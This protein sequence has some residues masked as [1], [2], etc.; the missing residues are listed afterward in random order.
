MIEF[1][2][3]ILTW[4]VVAAVALFWFR[5]E[6]KGLLTMLQKTR[7]AS[8]PNGAVIDFAAGDQVQRQPAETIQNR[9]FR[10]ETVEIDG[11]IFR[12]CRFENVILKYSG[13][14]PFSLQ[15]SQF[16]GSLQF[17]FA[18]PAAN[19]VEA[20]TAMYTGFGDLGRQ[21]VEMFFDSI[22]NP[23]QQRPQQK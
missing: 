16:H 11:K 8:L 7:R 20:L 23:R 10:D 21:M 19:A 13:E 3:V 14:Q 12:N 4:P 2:S 5:S 15:D 1:L 9:T 18:G 6:I 17:F 22:R